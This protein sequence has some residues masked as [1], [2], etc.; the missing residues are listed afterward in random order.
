MDLIFQIA[1]LIVSIIIHEVAHGYMAKALGD[2]TAEW[3]GRLT[4][5][6]LKHID[7]FGSIFLPLLTYI[8][9][10]FILGWA[11]PV[12]YNPY[13]LRPGRFS[14]ALVALA[15]PGVNLFIACIFGLILQLGGVEP[16]SAFE[17]MLKSI[18]W[19]NIVLSLFNLVPIPPL[20]GSKILFALL[21]ARLAWVKDFLERY[22]FVLLIVFIFFLWQSVLPVV[23]ALFHLISGLSL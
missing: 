11:K 6:P 14:E 2:N 5:N 8:S 4:L 17:Y 23:F 20:D 10:G 3:Q 15:G 12:P 19:V 1:I 18:I 16:L 7:P 9:G 13:N 21:P 22:G